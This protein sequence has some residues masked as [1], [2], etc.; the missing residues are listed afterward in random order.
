MPRPFRDRLNIPTY[1]VRRCQAPIPLSA[2]W[3]APHWAAADVARIAQFRPEGSDHRPESSARLLWET[4]GMH[5]I[6][7]VRDRYVRCVR[8]NYF[9]EVWKDSCVEFFV[10]PKA[11]GGYFNFEFNC[12][13]AHLVNYITDETRTATGFKRAEKLTAEI[14]L[15]VRVKSTLPPVI[16][17]ERPEPTVW[18]LQF[19]VPFA[20]LE[21]Y[22]GRLGGMHGQSWRGNFFKCADESSH[23][24]W[25]AWSAVDECNFHLPRCF[26]SLVFQP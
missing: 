17:P 4:A 15:Q 25:A 22:I 20:I 2:D 9:D 13:G 8:T 5:G 19:F 11:D 24:H 3:Q 18:A 23:P 12:G 7:L 21:N 16:D 14:G 10:Q 26:G 6:F 1:R